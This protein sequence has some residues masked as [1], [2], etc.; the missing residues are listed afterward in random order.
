MRDSTKAPSR[1]R[2]YIASSVKLKG[3]SSCLNLEAAVWDR[4][5]DLFDISPLPGSMR[6]V[7]LLTKGAF[8]MVFT[9]PLSHSI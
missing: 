7:V 8:R 1:A 5:A 6:D 4:I 2:I 9:V 3:G